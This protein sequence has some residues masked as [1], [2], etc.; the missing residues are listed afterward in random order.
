MTVESCWSAWSPDLIIA[1]SCLLVPEIVYLVVTDTGKRLMLPKTKL[2]KLSRPVSMASQNDQV[3]TQSGGILQ[4]SDQP[5]EVT[6]VSNEPII[7]IDSESDDE[8]YRV[9]V[10]SEGVKRKH[11]CA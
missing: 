10:R 2:L 7:I 8:N 9:Q 11:G 1:S 3:S 5:R 6:K 4:S